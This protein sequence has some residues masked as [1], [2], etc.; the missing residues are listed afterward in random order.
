MKLAIAEIRR[1]RG[2]WGSIIGAVGFIVFLVLVLAALADG[3]FIGSLFGDTRLPRAAL[4]AA[5]KDLRGKS[6]KAY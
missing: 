3:L 6:I 4:P 5:E 2:R 1:R